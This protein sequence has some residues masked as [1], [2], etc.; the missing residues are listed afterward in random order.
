MLIF[1]SYPANTRNTYKKRNKEREISTKPMPGQHIIEIK[2][3]HAKLIK[4]F[5]MVISVYVLTVSQARAQ[6]QAVITLEQ[7]T[8]SLSIAPYSYVTKDE[9][10]LLNPEILMA[11]HRNNL[12]GKR[13]DGNLI[14]L[15]VHSVPF[16]ILFTVHNTSD[17]EEWVIDFGRALD[18]RMGLIQQAHIINV[19][20]ASNNGDTAPSTVFG[21]ALPLR[22]TPGAQQTFIMTIEGEKGFPLILAPQITPEKTYIKKAIQGNP[23]N[24]VIILIF[25]SLTVFFLLSYYN[26]RN[27]ASLILAAHYC[28]LCG[29]FFTMDSHFTAGG[30]AKG[31]IMLT[32]YTVN[33]VCGLAAVKFF[34]KI[35][36][37][38]RPLSTA[39][40]VIFGS[41]IILAPFMYLLADAG[42]AGFIILTGIICF[43]LGL[44]GITGLSVKTRSASISALFCAGV[45][46]MSLPLILLCFLVV[47][48]LPVSAITVNLFWIF[49]IIG[50]PL[51]ITSYIKSNVHREIREEEE[52]KYKEHEKQSL[53]KLQKSKNSADQAR[54][55]RIIERERELMA[56]LKDRESKRTEEMRQAKELA[57]KANQAKSAFL[58]VVSHE[59]RTPMN[60]ILGMVQLLQNTDVTKAQRDYIDTIHKSG[61]SLV[62]LLN[63]ILDFEKIEHGG[64]EL[65][66]V[67]FNLPQLVN[68]VVILMS[69]HAAQKNI[70]LKA[71]IEDAVPEFVTGDPV[72]LR[73]VLLNLVNNA[74][75][76]T[77]EGHVAIEIK[78]R[79][80]NALIYFA[81]KD[82]GIGISE[83]AQSKL[84]T[85][86]KQ[87]ETSTSRKYGGTGLGLAI[88]NR[89]IEAMGGKID[90]K[91][92]ENIGSTFSF[93]IELEEKKSQPSNSETAKLKE[94]GEITKQTRPMN[95]LIVEDN[96]MNRKVLEGLLARNEHV[97]SMAANG[98]EALEICRKKELDL[99][100]MDIQMNGMSGLET[101]RKLRA[102]SDKKIASIP[103]IALTGNVTLEDIE[104]YFAAGM[105]GFIAKPVNAQ[106][107]YDTIYNASIGKF[108]NDLPDDF[109]DKKTEPAAA[110]PVEEK[111][112]T[113]IA[114]TEQKKE[115]PTDLQKY[116][117]RHNAK[118]PKEEN[119][120]EDKNSP[121]DIID[122]AMLKNLKDTL[123]E[124]SFTELLDGFMGKAAEI[125]KR[126][127]DILEEDNLLSLGARAHELKGMAGNFGMQALS[128]IAGE[129]ERAAKM[130]DK[131]VAV[132]QTAKLNETLDKTKTAF[133]KW[134][135]TTD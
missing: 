5:I 41:L 121:D 43:S 56:D 103:V 92:E 135:Q 68:D 8:A 57:D 79:S 61:E 101:T 54:L 91:S 77:Q 22:I 105:N 19:A 18:G 85:P 73:Q 128:I 44:G 48:L 132:K 13:G 81:V 24:I 60:G 39:L 10:R 45:V 89:L 94:T 131:T 50:A 72:R 76:F 107:L 33:L 28:V 120:S 119:P 74:L 83:E 55:L 15:G 30:L 70:A 82:T 108:E 122:A 93:E 16:W 100:L 32:V 84:F 25:V 109:F 110:T 129:I 7:N 20:S 21:T 67:D 63:D 35:T 27:H 34:M 6:E 75:K 114:P 9:E 58:A 38:I 46:F 42:Q 51:F 11:R 80:K 4:I 99:I 78:K 112:P 23:A 62:A 115:E 53:A 116:L 111:A 26:V 59:I 127:N 71:E 123:G 66:N 90:V 40:L 2:K 1:F 113:V 87:A 86:F 117:S 126:M 31:S 47:G 14:N 69:G 88:S 52:R 64:M 95:I 102:E 133:Q 36:H 29:L 3:N 125:I 97:L 130:S 118:A 124:E 65:E 104:K 37:D 134:R 12:R 106:N 49:H 98:L 96:E 17:I